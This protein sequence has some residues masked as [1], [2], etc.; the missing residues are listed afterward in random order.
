MFSRL[1]SQNMRF[2]TTALKETTLLVYND[3]ILTL[4]QVTA[5]ASSLT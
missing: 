4:V 2:Q 3:P 1:V 5:L